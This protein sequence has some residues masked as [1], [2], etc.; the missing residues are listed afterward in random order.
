M[1]GA[2]AYLVTYSAVEYGEVSDCSPEDEVVGSFGGQFL[3][4]ASNYRDVLETEASDHVLDG[5]DFLGDGVDEG[6]VG[7]GVADCEWYAG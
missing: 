4:P 1:L 3:G 6:E 5:Y 2:F 7:R